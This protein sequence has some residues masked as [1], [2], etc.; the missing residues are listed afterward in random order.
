MTAR[1]LL[2]TA[3][4]P[5]EAEFDRGVVTALRFRMAD[6]NPS[7]LGKGQEKRTVTLAD[8]VAYSQ[9]K[10]WLAAF[11]RGEKEKLATPPASR[12]EGTPFQKTV[13]EA[14]AGIAPGHT[15]TYGGLAKKVRKLIEA[16]Y[17]VE[18]N[19]TAR[20]VGTALSKNPIL[21]LIPCHRVIGNRGRL[22]GYSG[23]IARKADLLEHEK[24]F[25]GPGG[26]PGIQKD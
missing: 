25:F 15:I 11:E 4:G 19:V 6:E 21:L 13:W 22:T 18:V 16:A 26:K 7:S 10:C 23:G 14:A 1:F 24:R 9:L 3:F 20:S 8:K 5:M 12:L 17:G 2:D